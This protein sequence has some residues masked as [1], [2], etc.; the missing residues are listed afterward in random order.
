[1]TF[2]LNFIIFE[3][4]NKLFTK[5]SSKKNTNIILRHEPATIDDLN[6][7]QKEFMLLIIYQKVLLHF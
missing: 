5:N 6:L 7:H 3:W 4:S 1:M 2:F